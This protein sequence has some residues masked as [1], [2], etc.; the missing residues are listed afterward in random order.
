MQNEE[1]FWFWL[2]VMVSVV[3]AFVWALSSVIDVEGE[4]VPWIAATIIALA[5]LSVSIRA[6]LRARDI[7]WTPELKE[8]Q[9]RRAKQQISEIGLGLLFLII[10]LGLSKLG[11]EDIIPQWAVAVLLTINIAGWIWLGRR[12]HRRNAQE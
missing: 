4:R 1:D 7:V 5:L 2:A 3:A 8:A 6:G 12:L 10:M 11:R 9:K